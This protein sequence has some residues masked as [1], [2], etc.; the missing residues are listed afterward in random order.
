MDIKERLHK[1]EQLKSKGEWNELYRIVNSLIRTDIYK[2]SIKTSF[3]E[4]IKI[5]SIYLNM[6]YKIKSNWDILIEIDYLRET[7]HKNRFHKR[8]VN[9]D[10]S[11]LFYKQELDILS[12]LLRNNKLLDKD[13]HSINYIKKIF[14]D[15]IQI[16]EEIYTQFNEL[17]RLLTLRINNNKLFKFEDFNKV[18]DLLISYHNNDNIT[19]NIS[20][21]KSFD[22][23]DRLII[24]SNSKDNLIKRFED[25]INLLNEKIKI[26]NFGVYFK[27]GIFLGNKNN[28]Y[29][30]SLLTY[31][32]TISNVVC[33]YMSLG[34]EDIAIKVLESIFQQ[35]IEKT[36]QDM[37]RYY[38]IPT[39]FF[40]MLYLSFNM[41]GSKEYERRQ[42]ELI[43]FLFKQSELYNFLYKRTSNLYNQLLDIYIA[44]FYKK[45]EYEKAKKEFE[46]LKYEDSESSYYVA[47]IFKLKDYG[48]ANELYDKYLNVHNLLYNLNGKNNLSDKEMLILVYSAEA[49]ILGGSLESKDGIDRLKD[50]LL[51]NIASFAK[52]KSQISLQNYKYL[53]GLLNYDFQA[54]KFEDKEYLL[55]AFIEMIDSL[56]KNHIID[57]PKH[58]TLCIL[59]AIKED[60]Q[61]KCPEDI[62]NKL[63]SYKKAL[64]S[65]VLVNFNKDFASPY[66]INEH[67]KRRKEHKDKDNIEF[68]QTPIEGNV[69]NDTDSEVYYDALDKLENIPNLDISS[70][71]EE[72]NKYTYY[73]AH[74]CV[75]DVN[76]E[77]HNK[78]FNKKRNASIRKQ[79]RAMKGI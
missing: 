61:Y 1:V 79:H 69:N 19:G 17:I 55:N 4:C 30:I 62:I 56:L 47:S 49:K 72:V 13:I 43:S 34:E 24:K 71:I 20:L 23:I 7:F 74:K 58:L 57:Y 60:K 11:Y 37:F 16:N 25:I 66:R 44:H 46:R 42:D 36:L 3:Y 38:T 26:L 32:D 6:L 63:N 27:D 77:T 18:I 33:C 75:K 67:A 59:N 35:K 5:A 50:I 40:R 52:D 31:I 45:E 76:A 68:I 39:S 29:N 78:C 51:F 48:H 28:P 73:D 54:V 21:Q 64:S 70:E 15:H 2:R 12:D 9:C 8:N 22:E 14:K 41:N 10:C 65:V 53:I